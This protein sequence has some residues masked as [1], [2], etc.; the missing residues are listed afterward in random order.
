MVTSRSQLISSPEL[1]ISLDN[2]T[3]IPLRLSKCNNSILLSETL[4]LPPAIITYILVGYDE[5][6]ALFEFTIEESIVF[7]HPDMC[8]EH[9]YATCLDGEERSVCICEAGY[10]GNGSYCTGS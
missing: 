1:I 9:A 3:S 7:G 2:G 5:T 10:T 8:D 6:G 4:T